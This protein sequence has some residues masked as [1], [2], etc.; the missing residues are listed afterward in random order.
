MKPTKASHVFVV[1]LAISVTSF[2]AVRLMVSNGLAIPASPTNLLVTLAAIAVIL[3]GLSV[4]IWRYKAS[5]TQ[6]SKGPRPKRVDPFYAVR[7]LLLAKA[8]AL[9]GSGF[10]GWHL[11]AMIAQLSLPVSFTAALLQNSLGLV[12]SMVLTAA[13]IVSE[14]ICRLPDE[15]KNDQTDQMVSN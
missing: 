11:G 6:Y 4:P 9:T 5:L 15:P 8:S 13:A 3:L 12:A 10:I 14:Q 1:V 7:V 2:L